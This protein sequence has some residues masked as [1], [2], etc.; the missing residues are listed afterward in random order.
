M[1]LPARLP[2]RQ[3]LS[4]TVA[5]DL[6]RAVVSGRIAVGATLPS[7]PELV[8]GFGISKVVVREAIVALQA[9]GLVTVKQGKRTTVLDEGAWDVLSPMV[10]QAIRAEGRGHSLLRQ[11]HEARLIVEPAAAA[12]SA[13][14]ASPIRVAELSVLADR[15][16]EIATGSRDLAE[17]LAVDRAFH[18]VVAW[19]CE[20]VALRAMMRDLHRYMS[21]N[22]EDSRILRSEL[23]MLAEHHRRVFDAIAAR[24]PDAARNAMLEHI[25]WASRIETERAT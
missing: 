8:A 14:R 1:A 22:W 19:A 7:E 10:Q 24:D 13:E 17:F 3:R 4:D 25:S 5:E 23:P 2:I 6:A 16:G 15:L 21:F 12:L 18:D 20:N 11:L 9:A